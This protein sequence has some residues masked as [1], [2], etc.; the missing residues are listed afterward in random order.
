MYLYLSTRV[1]NYHLVSCHDEGSEVA[2]VITTIF[3]G[4]ET[5]ESKVIPY[6]IRSLKVRLQP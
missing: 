3:E 1:L 2:K 4:Y 5:L 6:V